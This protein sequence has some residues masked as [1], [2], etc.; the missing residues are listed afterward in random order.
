MIDMAAEAGI[1]TDDTPFIESAVDIAKKI[2]TRFEEG[3]RSGAI[4]MADLFDQQH[5]LIPGSN[6]EQ[7]MTKFTSFVENVIPDLLEQIL[8]WSPKIA[9]GVV[10]DRSGYLPVH[11]RKYS[12]PQGKDPFWNL[13]NCR[14]RRRMSV[15]NG[16]QAATNAG[17]T[18]V[19]RPAPTKM[20]G[21]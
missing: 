15:D 3:V 17:W 14:N 11:N 16:V 10:T 8:S 4:S 9:F 20:P 12:K 7:Y 6:P 21:E 1:Q 5:Q 19:C 13:A 2:G 18:T